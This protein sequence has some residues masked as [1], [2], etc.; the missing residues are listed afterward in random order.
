MYCGCYSNTRG[1]TTLPPQRNLVPSFTKEERFA[2]KQRMVIE[3]LLCPLRH[4]GRRD[5]FLDSWVRIVPTIDE[6]E[7]WKQ[8]SVWGQHWHHCSAKKGWSEHSK[9]LVEP[10]GQGSMVTKTQGV[11]LIRV[12][13]TSII[14]SRNE[15]TSDE[16]GN[17]GVKVRHHSRLIMIRWGLVIATRLHKQLSSFQLHISS[18]T[19]SCSEESHEWNTF[20]NPIRHA[21]SIL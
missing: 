21:L 9:S 16:H 12:R 6:I 4:E 11:C 14:L 5:H 7:R 10:Q 19:S 2:G 13:D 3:P 8:A 17:A 20:A 18:N 1:V 15:W